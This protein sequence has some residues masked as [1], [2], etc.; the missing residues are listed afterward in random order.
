MFEIN[1]YIKYYEI[2]RFFRCFELYLSQFK[3]LISLKASVMLRNAS[4]AL[5]PLSSTHFCSMQLKTSCLNDC[6]F[7]L[8]SVDP[9]ILQST[10]RSDNIY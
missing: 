10:F 1:P 5:T 2:I 8:P 6:T 3:S 4:M 9:I 7:L